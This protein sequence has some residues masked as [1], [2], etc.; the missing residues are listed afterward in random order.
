M[1]KI[2]RRKNYFTPYLFL[3]LIL[4]ITQIN[5]DI[6]KWSVKKINSVNV[7]KILLFERETKFESKNRFEFARVLEFL[8][9]RINF[10]AEVSKS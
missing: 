3:S 4:Q 6:G 2:L 7:K 1:I 8:E 5:N 9:N 10:L